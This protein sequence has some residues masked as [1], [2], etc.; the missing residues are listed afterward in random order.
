MK[1]AMTVARAGVLV[2]AACASVSCS[3][4]TPRREGKT[5]AK[6]AAARASAPPGMVRI[7][8]GC[9]EMGD[10]FKEGVANEVPV[11][12]VCLAKAFDID[13]HEVTNVDY[14]ACVGAKR[15]SAPGMLSSKTR[16]SY[17][18]NP[19]YGRFPVI[20]VS[21]N[22][23]KAYC[24]WTGKRLPS[25]AEW[26]YAARGG[27]AGKRYPL[28][29]SMSCADANYGRAEGFACRD[30]GGLPNDT[31][32][33]GSHAANGYGLHDMAGNVWE[34]VNDGYLETYYGESPVNDPPGPEPEY[35]VVRGGAWPGPPNYLRVAYRGNYAPT[36]QDN[37]IGFRCAR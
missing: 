27:L 37:L 3:E 14:E 8:A 12:R 33:V 28:G 21:W 7:P 31:H 29:D 15:C 19:E 6:P 18:G 25:E 1:N 24:S 36:L 10:A 26:E 23:A 35:P 4:A 20:Y 13:V 32:A 9:F 22:Q 16:T 34:W 2:A 30:Q 17:Y 11:H 5:E